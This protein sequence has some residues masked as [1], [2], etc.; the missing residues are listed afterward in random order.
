M[1]EHNSQ[2]LQDA[3]ALLV[4]RLASQAWTQEDRDNFQGSAERVRRLHKDMGLS[5]VDI[6]LILEKH[7]SKV[8]PSSVQE[9]GLLVQG[10]IQVS[11][12]CPHHL[13]PVQYNI[14]TGYLPDPSC[15][16]GLSKPARIISALAN[17]FV[18]QEQLSADIAQALYNPSQLA[19]Y[20][21]QS[22]KDADI[23]PPAF[24]SSG[25]IVLLNGIHTC[26]ACRG[27]S[28][29]ASTITV[30]RTGIFA[31]DDGSMEAR[32]FQLVQL[33]AHTRPFSVGA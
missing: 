16:L 22:V 20:D 32:F 19:L 33:A 1:S 4:D 25:A 27:V 12:A 11:S 5:P 3:Y 13:L 21:V 9:T 6:A 29:S 26:M 24:R 31:E 15:L 30:H 28:S 8:F 18:L 17:R 14:F 10:P 23:R 7:M 2:D